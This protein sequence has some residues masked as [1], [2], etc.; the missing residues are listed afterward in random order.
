VQVHVVMDRETRRPLG[1]AYIQFGEPAS[2]VRACAQLDGFIFQ[3][4]YPTLLLPCCAARLTP[5]QGRLLHVIPAKPQ[6]GRAG[7]TE[8]SGFKQKKEAA[9][10]AGAG[11][12]HNWNTLFVRVRAARPR[13]AT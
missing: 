4:R 12:D 8:A 6:P 1:F 3:A 11:S 13:C 10:K 5:A 2:A 9:Q 7:A